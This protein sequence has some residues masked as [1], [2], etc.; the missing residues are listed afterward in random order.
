MAR[1]WQAASRLEP[2]IF[3]LKS[4]GIR[5]TPSYPLLVSSSS[6]AAFLGFHCRYFITAFLEYPSEAQLYQSPPPKGPQ[7]TALVR[8]SRCTAGLVC[9]PCDA[10]LRG[11]RRAAGGELGLEDSRP[12][13]ESGQ[14][15]CTRL[16]SHRAGSSAPP[17]GTRYVVVT[18]SLQPLDQPKE[19]AVVAGA[20]STHLRLSPPL[21]VLLDRV[22]HTVH[23]PLL[24]H[25]EPFQ[26]LRVQSSGDPVG[27]YVVTT[28][29][30]ALLTG[31]NCQQSG[32]KAC[33]YVS[34]Q[35]LSQ[36]L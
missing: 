8:R 35:L 24:L 15:G 21:W 29:P 32:D 2:D 31:H 4:H 14:R 12:G 11:L 19:F 16:S 30:I 26:V 7:T 27:T 25:L 28:H 23:G 13:R 22:E 36:G 34:K 1:E 3:G 5:L 6:M 20:R 33:G 17:A 18:P 10:E 9:L